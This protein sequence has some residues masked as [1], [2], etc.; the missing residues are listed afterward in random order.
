VTDE[1]D[2]AKAHSGDIKRF[3]A[4]DVKKDNDFTASEN[5]DGDDFGFT[6]YIHFYEDDNGP[7]LQSIVYRTSCSQPILLGD[8]IGNATLVEFVPE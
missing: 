7:M 5:L 3:F 2:A 8:V 1:D 6:T 4:G